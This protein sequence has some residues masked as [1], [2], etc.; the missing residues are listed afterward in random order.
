MLTSPIRLRRQATRAHTQETEVPIEQVKEHCAY[1][2]AA[3]SSCIADMAYYSR[4]H[5]AYEGY[6]DVGQN[7]RDGEA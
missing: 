4:I 2:D 3:Y 6:R 7:T 5:N 1:R